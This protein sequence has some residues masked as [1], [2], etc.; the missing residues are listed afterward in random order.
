MKPEA[1]ATFTVEG[2]FLAF[3][4]LFAAMV[5]GSRLGLGLLRRRVPSVV[6]ACAETSL[7]R[8]GSLFVWSSEALT[9]GRI[10]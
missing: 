8:L 10:Y 5:T 6:S 7:A 4:N 9:F 3:L 1:A 2:L